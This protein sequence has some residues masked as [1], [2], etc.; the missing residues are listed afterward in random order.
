M[1]DTNMSDPLRLQL[2]RVLD[3]E[4]AHI[5]FDKA[6][7]GL[8][9]DK[10][11]VLAPGIE[12]FPDNSTRFVAVA[13]EGIPAPTG[14]DKTSIVLF[15]ADDRPGNLSNPMTIEQLQRKFADLAGPVLGSPERAAELSEAIGAVDEATSV[16]GIGERLRVPSPS[17][18][19]LT[20]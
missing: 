18:L 14:H 16:S 17:D 13:R 11:G 20:A 1:T 5:G 19:E 4:E 6:I 12:D 7:D 10:R 3:W 9:P 15:Q 2:A 8:P